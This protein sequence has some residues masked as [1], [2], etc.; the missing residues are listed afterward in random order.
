MIVLRVKGVVSCPGTGHVPG[1]LAP[2]PAPSNEAHNIRTT[3]TLHPE[4]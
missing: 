2:T 4:P 3:Y 1:A